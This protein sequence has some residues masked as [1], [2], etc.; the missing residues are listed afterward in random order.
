MHG[1][2]SGQFWQTC[3]PRYRPAV[4]TRLISNGP[5]LV[6]EQAGS[7][8]Y[9][10]YY[11]CSAVTGG[12]NLLQRRSTEILEAVDIFRA[13]GVPANHIF[14]V[15]HSGGASSALV[16]AARAPEKVNAVIASAPGYGYAY[17][18]AGGD[19]FLQIKDIKQR[20]QEDLAV[21]GQLDALVFAYADDRISPPADM[22]FFST[23][24]RPFGLVRSR[25][26]LSLLLFTCKKWVLAS[27]QSS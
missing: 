23:N 2:V 8:E 22:A 16:A 4:T 6:G 1:T 7:F 24:S 25:V 9:A 12:E 18:G 27:H 13:A 11:L 10:L 5:E 20:W 19:V 14:L 21:N 15:G 26:M 3:Q 17:L